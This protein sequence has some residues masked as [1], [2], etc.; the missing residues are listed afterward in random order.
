MRKPSPTLRDLQRRQIEALR[1]GRRIKEEKELNALGLS[2]LA[3][4]FPPYDALREGGHHP[5]G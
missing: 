3:P 1:H 5:I 2:L 4:P